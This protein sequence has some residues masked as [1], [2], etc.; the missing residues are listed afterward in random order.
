MIRER[1]LEESLAGHLR[2]RLER[3]DAGAAK[4]ARYHDDPIDFSRNVFGREPWDKQAEILDALVTDDNV[5][6]RSCNGAGKTFLAALAA[7][8]YVKTRGAG[9]EVYLASTKGEQAEKGLWKEIRHLYLSAKQPLGGELP[10]LGKTGWQGDELEQI[11]VLT[12]KKA[13]AMAGMRSR[14]MMIVA[15]EASGIDDALIDAMWGMLS[16]GGK[17]LLIGNP[18][19]SEGAFFRSHRRESDWT[20]F[21][22]SAFDVPNI[23]ERRTVVEGLTTFG[24]VEGRKRDWGEDSALYKIRVLGQFVVDERG[25]PI[26]W[27]SIVAAQERWSS[28]KVE[29]VLRVGVDPA[30]PG[31]AGD[32]TSMTGVRGQKMLEEHGS[33]T[34]TEDEIIVQLLGFLTRHRTADETP[35]VVLDT[36]GPIGSKL[37]TR[38]LGVASVQKPGRQFKVFAVKSSSKAQR[39]PELYD[40]VREELFANLALWVKRGG[41]ITAEDKLAI[42][43]NTPNW[44]GTL[45]GRLKLTDKREIRKIIHR[46]PDRSDSLALAVWLPSAWRPDDPAAEDVVCEPETPQDAAESFDMVEGNDIWWPQG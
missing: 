34:W 38:L 43:L 40:R 42:E 22:I 16:G 35:E 39:E 23:I 2:E 30:G 11:A 5:T 3:L 33:E 20:R 15:D 46:S 19:R 18:M 21:G 8:W 13:E 29:G 14:K 12:A 41:A 17:F 25:K 44:K 1:S 36:D 6:V 10:K 37:F 27:D 9:A 7:W 24:W 31:E 28:T 45:E 26:P 32:R 4:F